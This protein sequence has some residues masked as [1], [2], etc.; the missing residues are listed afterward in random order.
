MEGSGGHERMPE[1]IRGGLVESGRKESGRLPAG[2][3]AARQ[4]ETDRSLANRDDHGSSA[5][6]VVFTHSQLA[7]TV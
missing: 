3:E 7:F 4:F 6:I 1:V 2:Q 5:Y